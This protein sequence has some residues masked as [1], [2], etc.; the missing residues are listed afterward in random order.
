VALLSA[1]PLLQDI[2]HAMPVPVAILNEKSQIVLTNRC[3]HRVVSDGSQCLLGKR[4]GEVLGC[5]R[6][7]HGADGCGTSR[8]CANCGAAASILESQE[9][10]EQVTCAFRLL[11]E[12]PHGPE[13]SQLWVTATPL[14]VDGRDFTIFALHEID[15]RVSLKSYDL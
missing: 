1:V 15:A 8:R 11:R 10:R 4:H 14:Q 7:D 6:S 3:W 9:T 12:T 5:V 13:P 2:I